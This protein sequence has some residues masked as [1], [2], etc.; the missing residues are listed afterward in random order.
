MSRQKKFSSK[1]LINHLENKGV[2]FEKCSKGQ[3][4]NFIEKNNLYYKVAAFRKNFKKKDDKYQ[5][6]DFEYLKDLASLDFQIRQ[7]LLKISINVE[8]FIKTELA[9]QINNNPKENGYDIVLEFK[10][11]YPK[12][13]Y[14]T[15]NYFKKSRYQNDMFIKRKDTTPY[16]V[17]L[18]HMDYGSLMDF[19]QMYYEKYEPRSLKK[20]YLLGNN[21]RFIRNACAHNSILLLN[22]FKDDNKLE[23]V[24]ALV[25]TLASQTNLL[26]YKN[27]AKVNDLLSLFA[28]SKTYC[29]PA[30]YKYQKQDI[31]YFITRC[32]RH[33]EYYLKNP[34][35]TKMF[36]IF[37]KIVDIL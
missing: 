30:V 10:N 1:E 35:L 19:L 33:K 3:A 36:I 6:L 9:R 29:S 5:N 17:L 2:T 25:T 23:N 28:L 27:Y 8:H 24:N 37:Q 32:Q 31:D 15:R 22:V 21:A 11:S 34:F 18:E 7:L 12:S 4:I 14:K 16:W 13:Y 20:A 26:K